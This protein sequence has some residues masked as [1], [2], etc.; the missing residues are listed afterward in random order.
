M[1]LQKQIQADGQFSRDFE[2]GANGKPQAQWNDF[3]NPPTVKDAMDPD[4][5]NQFTFIESSDN[6]ANHADD[7]QLPELGHST[8]GQK[9]STRSSHQ[10]H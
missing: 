8:R 1:Q 9:P 10:T 4:S 6:E 3:F 2:L 5:Q 7:Y